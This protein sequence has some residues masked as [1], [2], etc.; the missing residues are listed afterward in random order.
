MWKGFIL[1][2]VVVVVVAA[3]CVWVVVREGFISAAAAN[4]RPVWLEGWVAGN[5]LKGTLSRQAPKGRNPVKLTEDNLIE[6]IK[7][8]GLNCAICHGSAKG[9][10]TATPIAK[11]EYPAPPQLAKEGVEDD[12]PGWTFWKIKNGIRWTGMPAWQDKLNDRQIWTITLFLSNMD[13]LPPAPE[14]V[15]QEVRTN[16]PS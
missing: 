4:A 14:Q 7:L 12:P 2:V 15:W 11:G 13:K 9:P 3:A 16:W 8:Y 5:S 1:G 6:G 10:A